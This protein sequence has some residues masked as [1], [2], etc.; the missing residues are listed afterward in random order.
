MKE[1][2]FEEYKR[3]NARKREI[4]RDKALLRLH[5]NGCF[6]AG[7]RD[8]EIAICEIY[9]ENGDFETFFQK[10]LEFQMIGYY[11]EL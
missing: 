10:E 5:L 7:M 9:K 11:S 3:L 6:E 8:L 4:L 1:K 2:G